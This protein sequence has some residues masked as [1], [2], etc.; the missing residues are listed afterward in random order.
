MINKNI[1]FSSDFIIG[2]PGEEDEDFEKTMDLINE[3]EFINSYSFIYS[4]RPGTSAANLDVVDNDKT[5]K[6]LEI[7]QK[8][9][10]ENQLE[11]NKSLEN[12]V[13]NV[14]VENRMKDGVKLFG[15]TEFMTSVIF[16]GSEENI[17]NIVQVKITGSNQNSLFGILKENYNKRVA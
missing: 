1:K 16:D 6:R 3:I 2:Y 11:R 4:P 15:R 8:K 12:T 5:K 9:L 13:I 7:I 14:L 17:G 10:F